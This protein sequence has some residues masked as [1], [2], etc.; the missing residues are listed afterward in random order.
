MRPFGVASAMNSGTDPVTGPSRP[1]FGQRLSG[2]LRIAFVLTQ[3][4][5][6]PVDVTVQLAAELARRDG[7]EVRL[8]APVPARG[9]GEVAGLLEESRVEGK[10]AVGA[11]RAARRRILDWRP[12][13][14]HAEDRRSGLV[15]AALRRTVVHTYHGVPDDV[16]LEWLAGAARPRPPRYTRAVLS[17]DAAVARAVTRTVVVT[18]MM[19]DVLV[20]R[21]RVPARKVVH[22]DNGL[23]LPPALPIRGPVRRLLFVG[24]LV[25]RKG[26]HLLLDALADPRLPADLTL[27]VAGDGP[28]RTALEEQAYALGLADRVEF[29]GFREDV[30]KLLGEADAF[31][32]PSQLEQQPLVLIEALAAGLPCLATDV[33]GVA[34]Q[35]GDDGIVVAPNSAPALADGLLTLLGTDVTDLGARAAQRARNRVSIERCANRHLELYRS[36]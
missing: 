15:C 20:R 26:V 30:P 36:L 2:P 25:P 17:A 31:V 12:D 34:D 18:P 1:S 13:V 11:I 24:L 21:L 33:G 6:G 3:D 27:R 23:R 8:F 16:P 14:V 29:L 5:G 9:A 32:L 35:L 19:A 7:V 4:R 22:I 28:E 10:G